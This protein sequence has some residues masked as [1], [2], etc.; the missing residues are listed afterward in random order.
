MTL[1]DGTFTVLE[2]ASLD[3]SLGDLIEKALKKRKASNP[4]IEYN[5]NIEREDK[6]G[7]ALD[8]V[9]FIIFIL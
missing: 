1:P 4:R 9:P 8:K 7:E 2:L 6:P 5:Y 3:I